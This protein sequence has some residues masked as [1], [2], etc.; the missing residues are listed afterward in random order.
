MGEKQIE[1][2]KRLLRLRMAQLRRQVEEVSCALRLRT[3][4]PVSGLKSASCVLLSLAG[5]GLA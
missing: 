4:L 3:H 2:D 1:I 5:H